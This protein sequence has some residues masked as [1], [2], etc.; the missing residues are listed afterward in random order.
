MIKEKIKTRE[1]LTE[2]CNLVRK[3]GKKIGFSSGSF[4]ILHAGHVIYL[5][6]AKGLCDV[7]VVGVNSDSSVKKYKGKDRPIIPE[8]QR[9][10]LVAALHSVDYVFLFDERRNKKNIEALKPDFYIKAGD[11]KIEELTSKKY[12]EEYSGRTILIPPEEGVSTTEIIKKIIRRGTKRPRPERLLAVIRAVFLD[13]DGVINKDIGYLHEPEKFELLPKATEGLK[14]MQEVGYRLVVI[15][16]QPGIGLGYY[17]KEDFF[18]VNKEML[19][20]LSS[21]NI[22]I[23]K[24]YFCPHSKS[25]K[26]SCRKPSIGLIERSREELNLD[27]KKSFVI[28][29]KSSDILAGKK[30]G[31]KTILIGDDREAKPDFIARNL[32]EAATWIRKETN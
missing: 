20:Q 7:L 3:Q 23:D 24:I 30:A 32:V 6:K 12:V 9:I 17:T 25:E 18:K 1:E 31:M 19:K 5:E 11:Y 28:G 10:G 15:T 16:N 4:D 29:D 27:L 8:K 14:L 22:L 13:R 2:I 26:C 21:H